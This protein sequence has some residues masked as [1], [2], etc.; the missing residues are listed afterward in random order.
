MT[1]EFIIGQNFTGTVTPA[2]LFTVTVEGFNCQLVY[3]TTNVGA[4]NVTTTGDDADAPA[5]RGGS[6]AAAA[7]PGAGAGTTTPTTTNTMS[8]G[9]AAAAPAALMGLLAGALAL[10]F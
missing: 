6:A 4:P 3:N 7:T 2:G 5:A 8:S 1:G 9:G 10:V